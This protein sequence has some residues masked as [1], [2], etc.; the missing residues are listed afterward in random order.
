MEEVNKEL[1]KR[2]VEALEKIAENIDALTLW[3]EDIDK[4]EW[5]ERIQW[6]LSEFL[7]NTPTSHNKE[8]DI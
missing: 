2:K 7:K 4:N 3:F 8:D 5:G 1:E 6:Y